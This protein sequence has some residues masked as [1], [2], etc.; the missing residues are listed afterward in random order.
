M[1][2]YI[3]AALK[4]MAKKILALSF[5]VLFLYQSVGY[6]LLQ[7]LQ[8]KRIQLSNW[9]K[10]NEENN[11]GEATLILNSTDS[12]IKFLNAHEIMFEGKQYDVKQNAQKQLL[13]FQDKKE[14][15]I[16]NKLIS[17]FSVE[18]KN[19]SSIPFSDFFS[20]IFKKD[21][22]FQQENLFALNNSI[23]LILLPL[24]PDFIS[25]NAKEIFA[26]PPKFIS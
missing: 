10:L 26:P 17:V 13:C 5:A 18:K 24:F 11:S 7:Q 9:E 19:Q 25:V 2:E 3:L 16:L 8:Q 23:P 22:S 15:K 12:R 14:E 4:E 6:I 20:K 21:Y 1:K